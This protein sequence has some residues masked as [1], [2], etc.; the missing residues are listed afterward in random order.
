MS[1]EKSGTDRFV[2]GGKDIYGKAK[3]IAVDKTKG[4]PTEM[5]V[6]AFDGVDQADEVL[7]TLEQLDDDRLV[8]LGK[9]AVVRRDTD[10]VIDVEETADMDTKES[11]IAGAVAGGL[12]GMLTG[13]GLMGG[14]LLGAGGGALAAKGLDLG[15]DDDYL[16]EVAQ[17]L[18]PDSSAIVATVE[19]TNVDAAMEVLDRFEGGTILHTTLQPEITARLS[20]AV[21]D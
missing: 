6:V 2:G 14:A 1:D 8:E 15:I 7:G 10:G 3:A 20:E 18:G 19:F 5:F 21:E 9:A 13:R 11:A 4:G 17:G 12:L 16:K